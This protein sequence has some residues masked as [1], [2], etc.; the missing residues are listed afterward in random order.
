MPVTITV[1]AVPDD[2]RD[3]LAA[4]A[5]RAGQSLQEFLSAELAALASRPSLAEAVLRARRDAA[6]YP[7]IGPADLIADLDADRR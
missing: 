3:E 7:P 1:R 5:A 2:V 6:H 4:R